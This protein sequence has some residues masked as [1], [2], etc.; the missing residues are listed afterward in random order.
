MAFEADIILVDDVELRKCQ[1]IGFAKA[2]GEG[3]RPFPSV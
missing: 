3:G 1:P 2:I